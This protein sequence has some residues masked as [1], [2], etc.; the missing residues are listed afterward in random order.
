LWKPTLFFLSS[1]RCALTARLKPFA[2]YGTTIIFSALIWTN[3]P[4]GKD[5]HKQGGKAPVSLVLVIKLAAC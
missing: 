1:E 2:V 3:G 5:A 4:Q